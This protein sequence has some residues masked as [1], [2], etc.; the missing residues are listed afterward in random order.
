MSISYVNIRE[1]M[2]RAATGQIRPDIVMTEEEQRQVEYLKRLQSRTNCCKYCGLPSGSPDPD[3]LCPECRE[4]F[5]HT[6]YSEL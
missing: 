2:Q 5:G 1:T 6:F 4:D 3:V